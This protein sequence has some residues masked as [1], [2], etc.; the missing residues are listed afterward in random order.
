M[1]FCVDAGNTRIKWAIGSGEHWQQ[2]GQH[3]TAQAAELDWSD[4][5]APS[6]QVW[7]SN[8]AGDAVEQ[9]LRT[10]C[11]MRGWQ[12][13]FIASE[14]R[15]AG[16]HNAYAHPTQLGVDRWAALLGAWQ[17]VQGA[18]V[19]VNCG[20]ATTID[21]LSEQGVFLGGLIVPGLTLMQRSLTHATAQLPL[22]AGCYAAFPDNTQDALFSG[23]LQ[24]T[25]GAIERQR[26]QS[27]QAALLLTGGAAQQVLPYLPDARWAVHLVLQGIS[28][29]SEEMDETR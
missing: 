11:E 24:A 4:W 20:T 5:D 19:V 7:I 29:L 9:Q 3:P 22:G 15:R 8:V 27:P 2:F 26:A 23:A 17:Q 14:V 6:G 12:A 1:K 21:T 13:R 16:V 28:R 10:A 18:V 25:L